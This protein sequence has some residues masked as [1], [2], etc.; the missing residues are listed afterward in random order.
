MQGLELTEHKK[1]TEK[2]HKNESTRLENV[3]QVK[4]TVV[5]QV[6]LKIKQVGTVVGYKKHWYKKE[7]YIIVN[8]QP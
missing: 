8:C 2:L 1:D 6:N 3:N 7:L 4:N 5:N